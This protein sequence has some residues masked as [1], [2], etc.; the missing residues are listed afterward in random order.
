MHAYM[1]IR[2]YVHTCIRV[3]VCSCACVRSSPRGRRRDGPLGAVVP[4]HI[5]I[6]IYIY[7]CVYIY[8]YIHIYTYRIIYGY[9]YC[10]YYILLLL[11]LLLL[12]IYRCCLVP[13]DAAGLGRRGA[14]GRG[15]D[16][17]STRN[18]TSNQNKH[19]LD[20]KDTISK[21]RMGS[22]LMGSLRISCF[23]TEGPFGY[24]R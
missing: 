19:K 10:Y 12:L 17:V 18:L 8:I 21:H 7:V 15:T 11:L 23:L 24:S 6:Y 5:H 20:R 9:Y 13:S 22:A 1:Y 3:C 14:L 16:G 2:V 4:K